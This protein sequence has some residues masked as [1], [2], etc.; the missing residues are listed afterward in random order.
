MLAKQLTT[1]VITL[2]VLVFMSLLTGGGVLVW[3]KIEENTTSIKKISDIQL[4][5][6]K[7]LAT[8]ETN[9]QNQ[10]RRL[11][12]LEREIRGKSVPRGN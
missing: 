5:T 4:E 9:D 8:I 7:I 1:G 3:S 10:E 2:A 12:D 6:V 11:R